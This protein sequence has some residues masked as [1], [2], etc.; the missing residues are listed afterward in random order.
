MQSSDN[1]FR[2]DVRQ[3]L[4]SFLADSCQSLPFISVFVAERPQ[5]TLLIF[6]ASELFSIPRSNLFFVEQGTSI[7]TVG[8]I[9]YGNHIVNSSLIL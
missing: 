9:S 7:I 6:Y 5:D 8:E 2:C 3:C 4:D 1:V